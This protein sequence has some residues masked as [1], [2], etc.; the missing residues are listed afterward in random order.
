MTPGGQRGHVHSAG[1]SRPVGDGSFAGPSAS[2]LPGERG[3]FPTATVGEKAGFRTGQVLAAD[4]KI[5]DCAFVNMIDRD[6][7]G[8]VL[9][10][11]VTHFTEFFAQPADETALSL[12]FR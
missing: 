2:D 1:W 7:E 11:F 12:R 4:R 5:L 6:R 3:A 10:D 8:L 9:T